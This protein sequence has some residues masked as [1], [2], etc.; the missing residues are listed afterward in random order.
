LVYPHRFFPLR[1]G[2]VCKE[3]TAAIRKVEIEHDI[4]ARHGLARAGVEDAGREAGTANLNFQVPRRTMATLAETK[5]GVKDVQSRHYGERLYAT[6]RG[7]GEVNARCDL[8]GADGK[9]GGSGQLVKF[10]QRF[11]TVW[12]GGH[13]G[14]SANDRIKTIGA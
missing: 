10:R 1:E 6:N 13:F 11:G 5:G 8:L 3:E 12:Y 7:G 2:S 9:G 14:W 4:L